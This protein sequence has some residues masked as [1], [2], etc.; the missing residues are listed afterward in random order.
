MSHSMWAFYMSKNGKIYII[1]LSYESIMSLKKVISFTISEENIEKIDKT[2][3]AL[4]MNRSEL[5]ELIVEKGFT[6]SDEVENKLNNITKLQS[7]AKEKI[8]NR[9]IKIR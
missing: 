7:E 5:M 3:K 2:S 8:Q 4:G 6:F 9:R 1:I